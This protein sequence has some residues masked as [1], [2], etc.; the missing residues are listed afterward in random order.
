MASSQLYLSLSLLF[1]AA[2]CTFHHQVHAEEQ[3]LKFKLDADILQESIVRHVN[4]HPQAGWKAT[5]NPRFSNYSVSQFKYL[6]GVKQT[7]EKDLKSTPVLS[8]PK[9]LRL[10]KSFDAREAWPQC[11]SIGTILG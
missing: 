7:P 3:V 8:H 11:I 1:L 10:P 2:V 9:S 6:L 5:M 4:E